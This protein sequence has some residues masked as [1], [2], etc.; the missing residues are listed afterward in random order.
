LWKMF[1]APLLFT[2]NVGLLAVL[3]FANFTRTVNP[4]DNV[5]VPLVTDTVFAAVAA[6]VEQAPYLFTVAPE[7]RS[8]VMV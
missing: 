7:M 4:E 1:F 5:T 6:A 3:A 2:F 8:C